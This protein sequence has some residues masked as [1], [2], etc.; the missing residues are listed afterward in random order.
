MEVDVFCFDYGTSEILSINKVYPGLDTNW[1]SLRAQAV[2]CKIAGVKPVSS[3]DLV[4]NMYQSMHSIR[5]VHLMK[6]G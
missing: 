4:M 2:P 6:R 5:I 1:T 3:F